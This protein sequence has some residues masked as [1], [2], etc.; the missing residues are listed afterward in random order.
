MS[1]GSVKQQPIQMKGLTR[2]ERVDALSMYLADSE[3][4]CLINETEQEPRLL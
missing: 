1:T 3:I 2:D 4:D